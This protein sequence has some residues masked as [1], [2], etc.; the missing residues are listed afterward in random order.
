MSDPKRWLDDPGSATGFER[1]LLRGARDVEP[2]LGAQGAV[3]K[4]LAAQ[5]VVGGAVGVAG[6]AGTAGTASAATAGSSAGAVAG[7]G[8]TAAAVPRPRTGS[9]WPAPAA[10]PRPV[11]RRPAARQ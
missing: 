1:D 9:R 5:L 6:A 7:A 10:R 11:V 2:P 8:S 4:A 3:W